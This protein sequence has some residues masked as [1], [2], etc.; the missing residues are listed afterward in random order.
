[1]AVHDKIGDF[2]TIIRNATRATKDF[3]FVGHSNL[4][5][6]IAQILKQEGFISDVEEVTTEKG[7]KQLKL[8]FKYVNG[9]SALTDIQRFS[10]PGCRRY[11]KSDEIPNVLDG[12]GIAIISTSKGILSDKEARQN[13][14]GGELICTLW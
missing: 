3:T 4:K 8:V 5:K 2:L 9:T 12:L 10:K 6:S 1:M 7:F 13:K 14:V 11:F